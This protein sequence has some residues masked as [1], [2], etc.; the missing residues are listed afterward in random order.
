MAVPVEEGDTMVV[1]VEEE[2]SSRSAIHLSE[3]ADLVS[4]AMSSLEC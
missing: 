4:P 1:P 3:A 2:I